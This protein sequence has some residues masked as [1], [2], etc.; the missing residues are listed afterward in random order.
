MRGKVQF[1][2]GTKLGLFAVKMNPTSRPPWSLEQPRL[3]R[4]WWNPRCIWSNTAGDPGG[5]FFEGGDVSRPKKQNIEHRRGNGW[6]L[7][8]NQW[9]SLDFPYI[10]FTFSEI[11][12]FQTFSF[13]KHKKRVPLNRGGS[14]RNQVQVLSEH[15]VLELAGS[16]VQCD[17]LLLGFSSSSSFDLQRLSLRTRMMKNH[18]SGVSLML[19]KTD[20]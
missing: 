14:I 7:V 2:M 19:Q 4:C 6:V 12:N 18:L 9:I 3:G 20:Y 17:K 10:Y 16:E 11:S 5:P 15:N 1:S 13:L 8:G